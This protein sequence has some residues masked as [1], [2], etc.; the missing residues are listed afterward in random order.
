MKVRVTREALAEMRAAAARAAPEECCGILLGEG[1]TIE[2]L[3][4]TAN[5][6]ADRLH[7]FEIDP[8]ALV[9]AHRMARAGGPQVIGYF[10]SHPAGL[11]APSA[12]DQASGAR[13]GRV[14]AI[15]GADDVTF[16][17][18]EIMGFVALS[19]AIEDR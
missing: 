17:R 12:L 14:W 19:Y 13:D 9:D 7:N 11:A 16:W 18:D 15:V 10:H 8:Q 1:S 3:C 6:A 2:A 5:L 4:E